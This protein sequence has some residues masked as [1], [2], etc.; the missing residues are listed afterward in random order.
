MRL[1]PRMLTGYGRQERMASLRSTLSAFTDSRE[2]DRVLNDAVLRCGVLRR[3][4]FS[5]P[6]LIRA[7]TPTR[8]EVHDATSVGSAP[9][10]FLCLAVQMWW[11]GMNGIK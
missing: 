2:L 9:S 5:T 8:A 11:A 4:V 3:V 7:L 1:V 6:D 10:R